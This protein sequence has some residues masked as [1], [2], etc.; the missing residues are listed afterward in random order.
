MK[1]T[2]L[3]PYKATLLTETIPRHYEVNETV[4]DYFEMY[5][6]LLTHYGN[7]P[8]KTRMSYDA[9]NQ[10]GD[11][12]DTIGFADAGDEGRVAVHLRSAKPFDGLAK[13]L[14]DLHPDLH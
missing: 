8:D 10:V 12:Y 6:N 11:V 1:E 13:I 2:I 7:D 3:A 5:G 9:T 4:T 14:E